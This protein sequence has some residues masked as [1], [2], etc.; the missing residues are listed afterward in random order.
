MAAPMADHAVT[1]PYGKPGDWA[2]GYH[3][4]EDY[5]T[6]GNTGVP[7]TATKSG[8][9]VGTGNVWGSDYGKTVVVESDGIRH[10]YC[11]LSS[12]AVAS[13]DHVDVGDRIGASGNTGNSTGPHLHYEER[14]SP[15]G[16][17]DHRA[18]CYSE[19]GDDDMAKYASFGGPGITAQADGTWRKVKLSIEH[20]DSGDVHHGE[21]AAVHLGKARYTAMVSLAEC[22]HD[23]DP[24]ATLLVRW[25][26]CEDD[27]DAVVAHSTAHEYVLSTGGTDLRDTYVD[28]C[29]AG[30]YVR[31]EVLA[32]GGTVTVAA[33]A[34]KVIYWPT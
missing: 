5:S 28:T 16:Y 23:D 2:A 1:T 12:I 27:G 20:A 13:G 11:H 34:L 6:H 3:T 25:A 19:D 32:R 7:V 18:P 15:Y 17:H 30:H 8:K 24:G 10:G 22:R 14:R 4:G 31:A 33:T 29:G 21:Y 26:E 9:V